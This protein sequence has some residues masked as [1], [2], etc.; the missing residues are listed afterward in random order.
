MTL[1]SLLRGV[2]F[3]ASCLIMFACA[4][5]EESRDELIVSFDHCS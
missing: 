2:R 1:E 4:L 5:F 3:S